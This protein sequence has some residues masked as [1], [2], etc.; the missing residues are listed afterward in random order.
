VTFDPNC[1]FPDRDPSD[2]VWPKGTA[3]PACSGVR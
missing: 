2:N 3:L 1:R